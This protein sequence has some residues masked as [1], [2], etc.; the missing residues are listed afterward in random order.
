LARV[1]F[2]Q[3][4]DQ[5]VEF[6][7]GFGSNLFKAALA[8]SL[9]L[10]NGPMKLLHCWGKGYC[11]ACFVEVLHGAAALPERTAVERKKL[12]DTPENVRLAC[13]V[14]L[15]GDLVIRKPR[16]ILRPKLERAERLREAA[17]PAPVAVLA[18]S[19]GPGGERPARDVAAA[20]AASRAAS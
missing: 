19:S 8:Q 3:K 12:R 7:V 15:T 11:G 16:G 10:F 6:E 13:Q 9:S 14:Q 18:R 5:I 2:I 1:H 20:P 4:D 17:P